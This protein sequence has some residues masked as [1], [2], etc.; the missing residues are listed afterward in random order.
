MEII[1][2]IK[3][4]E[5]DSAYVAGP[6][7]QTLKALKSQ[8]YKLISL[9]EKAGLRMQ[10]GKD[11]DVSS[12]GNWV[13]EGA[14]YVPGKGRFITRHSTVLDHPKK[15]TQAHRNGKEYFVSDE[16]VKMTLEDSVQVPYKVNEIPTIRFGE[17]MKM[18]LEDSVQVIYDVNEIPT[19]RFGEDVIAMFCFGKNAKDYGLF[20]KDAGISK[21]PLWFNEEDY[22][23]EQGK[24]YA[25]QLWLYGLNIESALGGGNRILSCNCG[26]R[27]VK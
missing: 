27:G 22:V 20:L 14:L 10:Q 21:M 15:A 18:T 12:Q 7:D 6:F 24:P 2:D 9:E 23:Q 16:Q 3:L 17:E 8:G 1:N 13:K 19:D 11:Y 5:I 26:S 25:N 4:K